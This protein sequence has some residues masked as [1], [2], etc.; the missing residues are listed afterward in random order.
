MSGTSSNLNRRLSWNLRETVIRTSLLTRGK[1][2]SVCVFA[3]PNLEKKSH[4]Y[5]NTRA[6]EPFVGPS[7]CKGKGRIQIFSRTIREQHPTTVHTSLQNRSSRVTMFS[8]S[9][10]YRITLI[11]LRT[12][13]ASTLRAQAQ[14]ET[15][16][17]S[18]ARATLFDQWCRDNRP[19]SHVCSDLSDLPLRYRTQR[20]VTRLF[21]QRWVISSSQRRFSKESTKMAAALCVQ[22]CVHAKSSFSLPKLLTQ[23]TKRATLEGGCGRPAMWTQ[24]RNNV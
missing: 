20:T 21:L 12:C 6:E 24:W 10:R 19:K 22:I 7:T 9:P 23:G 8:C 4:P 1:P 16:Q 18:G 13:F 3:R 14:M 2:A 17:H 15:I 5:L 11:S